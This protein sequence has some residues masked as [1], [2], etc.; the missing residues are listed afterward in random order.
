MTLFVESRS[1][2][3]RVLGRRASRARRRV[4][5]R[6]TGSARVIA[7]A[8]AGS[9]LALAPVAQAETTSYRINE[10]TPAEAVLTS[11]TGEP[12]A[13][14]GTQHVEGNVRITVDV[15]GTRFH[16]QELNKFSL[17][18]TGT[19][20]G[21]VYQNQQEVMSEHNGTFTL[22]PFGGGWA[23]YEQTDVTNMV[24]LRQG[25]AV[26]VDD[27]YLRMR[28]HITVNA[29]GVVTIRPPTF[30]IICR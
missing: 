29:N 20:S 1:F 13:L 15:S 27:L 6:P 2:A 12:V 7:A 10:T 30:E 19:L 24:L 8:V 17:R 4:K 16:S 21:A 11:C 23:P 5:R 9:A 28:Y 25:E 26:R 22:D 18:G 3:A 14:T